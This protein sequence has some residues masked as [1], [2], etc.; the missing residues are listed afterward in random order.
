MRDA[1]CINIVNKE[2][3]KRI[4]AMTMVVKIYEATIAELIL[5]CHSEILNNY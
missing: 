5:I 1:K 2:N 4:S 3:N